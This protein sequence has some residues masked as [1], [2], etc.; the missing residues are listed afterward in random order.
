[1]FYIQSKNKKTKLEEEVDERE[2]N[3]DRA[4][5]GATSADSVHF[6]SPPSP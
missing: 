2:K 5:K 3:E 4:K 1:M 6:L